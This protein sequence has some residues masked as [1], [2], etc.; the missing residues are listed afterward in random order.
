VLCTFVMGHV[1]CRGLCVGVL[2]GFV[3]WC[4]C[5]CGLGNPVSGLGADC[6]VAE[7]IAPNT[8]GS[9]HLYNTLELL[10]MGIKVLETC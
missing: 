2:G 3:S 10:M 9:N 1:G 5:V 4:V 8:T 6:V 7:L